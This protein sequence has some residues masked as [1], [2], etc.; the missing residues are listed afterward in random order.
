[1]KKYFYLKDN[2]GNIRVTIDE[3]GNVKG[4]N[5]YY[6]FGLRMPG[7]SMNTALNYALYKYSSKELDWVPIKA[8]FLK[9]IGIKSSRI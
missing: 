1:M 7:R 5:D 3:S 6:P 4:Y 9:A 2:L 8:F